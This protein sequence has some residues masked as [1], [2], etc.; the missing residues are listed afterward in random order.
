MS[1]RNILKKHGDYSKEGF[2]TVRVHGLQSD[3]NI[4]YT[5]PSAVPEN[6]S[7]AYVLSVNSSTGV[8]ERLDKSTI[9]GGS[10]LPSISQGELLSADA[11]NT[12][13]VLS[14]GSNGQILSVDSSQ[15]LGL[16]W[17]N[18]DFFEVTDSTSNDTWTTVALLSSTDDTSYIIKATFIGSEVGQPYTLF[19]ERLVCFDNIGGT[20]SLIGV[21]DSYVN[22]TGAPADSWNTR[23][24][25]SGNLISLDIQGEIATDINWSCKYTII[26]HTR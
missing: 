3:D 15:P 17:I 10:S 19:E 9:S 13:T 24:A 22:T 7:N 11:T 6:N 18:K 23:I 12:P 25:A 20:V 2:S 21:E 4:Q 8:I 14:P 1:I 16:S 5:D 26:T